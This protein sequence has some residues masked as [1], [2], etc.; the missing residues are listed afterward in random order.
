MKH[1]VVI[2]S[3]VI[4]FLAGCNQPKQTNEKPIITVSVLPQK[5]FAEKIVGDFFDIHV[6]IPPGVGPASYDPTPKQMINLAKSSIYFKIGYIGFELNWINKIMDDYPD[7]E[8][9]D[10]SEG[11]IFMENEESH[12]DHKH[13]QKEPHIWMSPKNVKV[14]VSNML[15]EI[16]QN[17]PKNAEIYKTNYNKFTHELDSIHELIENKLLNIESKEFII[18][19]PA[20][21]YFAHDY[22]LTQYAMEIDGKEPSVKQM[23]E[24]VNLANEKNIKTIFVQKQF[25]QSEANTLKK[26]INGLV[27]PID[28]LDY[29]WDTQL[30]E[31]ASILS[32]NL[33]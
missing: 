5:Y 19:H 15:N 10:T 12:G 6:M 4:L 21:T 14:I 33:N 28:P 22:G 17:D 31:I 20:L 18:Y 26:E 11:I 3:I 32:D 13:H 25:N 16:I 27:I 2:F 7:I 9:I 1:I 24:L 8:F 29:N 23:K 30:V